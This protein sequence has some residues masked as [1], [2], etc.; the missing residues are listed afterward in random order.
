MNSRKLNEEKNNKKQTE[1][2][3]DVETYLNSEILTLYFIILKNG[4]TYSK[5]RFLE[6]A[7]PF[8]NTM[9]QRVKRAMNIYTNFTCFIASFS[10]K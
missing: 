7:R 6:Y 2:D 1:I 10:K 8:F 3:R 9:K 5:K 4:Q